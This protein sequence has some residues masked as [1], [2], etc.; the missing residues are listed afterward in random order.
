MGGGCIIL[1]K[2]FKT[3]GE[4]PGG[5]FVFSIFNERRE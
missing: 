3:S 5:L 1:L 4:M 2:F